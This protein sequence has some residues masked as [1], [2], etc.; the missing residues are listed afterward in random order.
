M[1]NRFIRKGRGRNVDKGSN[2][3]NKEN[4]Q[5]TVQNGR[6]KSVEDLVDASRET[7]V[8]VPMP[9]NK[10][11]SR[12]YHKS[13]FALHSD[14]SSSEN[15]RNIMESSKTSTFK[16]SSPLKKRKAPLPPKSKHEGSQNGTVSHEVRSD[17]SST[18]SENNNMKT[19]KSH[20]RL[21]IS[22]SES[23]LGKNEIGGLSVSQ[24][25]QTVDPEKTKIALD[26]RNLTNLKMGSLD[27]KTQNGIGNKNISPPKVN[28]YRPL[29]PPSV[30]VVKPITLYS[31][32]ENTEQMKTSNVKGKPPLSRTAQGISVEN[33]KGLNNHDSLANRKSAPAKPERTGSNRGVPDGKARELHH[34]SPSKQS[35]DDSSSSEAVKNSP[36]S[37]N[38]V[39]TWVSRTGRPVAPPR[40]RK[41][42]S[43][44]YCS[45]SDQ[46]ESSGPGDRDT[47][48]V[49]SSVLS[50]PESLNSYGSRV[51]SPRGSKSVGAN[52]HKF[53]YADVRNGSVSA[54]S[55]TDSV[56]SSA[57]S[58]KS[59]PGVT[60]TE[61]NATN[62]RW[63]ELEIQYD[64]DDGRSSV[65]PPGGYGWKK[66]NVRTWTPQDVLAWCYSKG[67]VEI[68]GMLEGNYSLLLKIN[69][70][71]LDSGA[72][73]LVIWH[74][75]LIQSRDLA[76]LINSVV[77]VS[78]FVGFKFGCKD[79]TFF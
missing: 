12:E 65:S 4:G 52:L 61:W 20:K 32:S 13:M 55:D 8:M 45:S 2:T 76:P 48:S 39:K 68:T 73:T 50:S 75:L 69:R 47:E 62:S 59:I 78:S 57:K 70:E 34:S 60:E 36:T 72:P 30:Q 29:S 58:C 11:G 10:F 18:S 17:A 67:L 79:L 14:D 6:S 64:E 51:T 24:Q 33:H 49:C 28:L 53:G 27:R 46:S 56:V 54:A 22:K 37:P 19:E 71:L 25:I 74:H 15:D 1:F 23:S 26:P 31:V 44:S 35:D 38:Q 16:P 42:K 63:N 41:E 5:A 7:P 3:G 40:R 21:S 9:S 43:K 66:K 77:L